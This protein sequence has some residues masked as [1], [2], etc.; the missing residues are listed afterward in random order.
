MKSLDLEAIK[1]VMSD[2]LGAGHNPQPCLLIHTA[3]RFACRY[4]A[5]PESAEPDYL[6]GFDEDTEADVWAKVDQAARAYAAR[7][8]PTVISDIPSFVVM[9]RFALV[10]LSETLGSPE[11]GVDVCEALE[12]AC[13][14]HYQDGWDLRVPA[15]PS[16]KPK[17]TLVES[18]DISA[19][20]QRGKGE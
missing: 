10:M 20:A 7:Q 15:P 17:L 16:W 9:V 2:D 13:R 14:L 1:S 18:D 6:A 12:A 3:Y 8:D 5:G 4:Y 19:S 11:E